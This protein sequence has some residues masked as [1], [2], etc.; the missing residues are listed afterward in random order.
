MSSVPHKILKIVLSAIVGFWIG[1]VAGSLA[2]ILSSTLGA[3]MFFAVWIGSSVLLYRH[4]HS[5]VLLGS[6]LLAGSALCLLLPLFTLVLGVALGPFGAIIGIGLAIAFAIILTPIGLVLAYFGYRSIAGGLSALRVRTTPETSAVALEVPSAPLG[7][8]VFCRFCGARIAP[9]HVFCAVCGQ[10]QPT[11]KQCKSEHLIRARSVAV[12]TG[13]PAQERTRMLLEIITVVILIMFTALCVPV[14]GR[15]TFEIST[16]EFH[17][18]QHRGSYVTF[19]VYGRNLGPE[20]VYG[21]VITVSSSDPASVRVVGS[22][23]RS[24]SGSYLPANA[25]KYDLGEFAFSVAESA[26]DGSYLIRIEVSYTWDRSQDYQT[27]QIEFT[28]EPTQA[29]IAAREAAQKTE[30]Q[31]VLLLTTTLCLVI[32]VVVVVIAFVLWRRTKPHTSSEP[33]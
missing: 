26:L 6:A 20:N 23:T 1:F 15:P 29:E 27:T 31:G 11:Q 25:M 8:A 4:Y 16:G 21:P 9:E 24:W 14:S 7:S 3:L 2:T 10:K 18:V 28:I 12:M 22:N 19:K 13:F 30:Q 32:L 5:R 33:T 17:K